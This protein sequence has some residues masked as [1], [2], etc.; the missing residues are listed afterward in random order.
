MYLSPVYRYVTTLMVVLVVVFFGWLADSQAATPE[1]AEPRTVILST[2]EADRTLQ[3]R[4]DVLDAI[5]EADARTA[6]KY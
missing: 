6:V 2:P 1:P 3:P 4:Q 5:A